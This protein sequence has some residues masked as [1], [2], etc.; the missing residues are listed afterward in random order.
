MIY[1]RTCPGIFESRP[2][3]FVA[4]V[5]VEGVT[6]TVHVKNTGRCKELLL[7]GAQVVLQRAEDPRRKTQ[8]DL[9]AVYKPSLGWVNIDSQ[10]SNRVVGEW[11]RTQGFSLVQ[12]EYTFGNS[13][14]DF[15]MEKAGARYLMEVKG[16]TL[17][18]EGIGYFPDA[19]TLRGV[20][21]LR[22]LADAAQNGW[23]CSLAF[24]IAMEGVTEVRPNDETHREFGLAL[25]EARAAGVRVLYLPCKVTP[26]TLE[27][28]GAP[29]F[30]QE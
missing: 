16:C 15:Y 27:V 13:R 17:E 1:E 6:E 25:A 29:S 2:N 18:R 21:H 26:N 9:I 8:Y 5:Q 7:P 14:M 23:H 19:P 30:W 10:A 24:V 22:E 20:K 3:R 4:R 11:L 28:V 12:P